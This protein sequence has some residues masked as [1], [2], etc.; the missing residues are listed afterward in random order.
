MINKNQ[1]EYT[2]IW[3]KNEIKIYDSNV[4]YLKSINIGIFI[5]I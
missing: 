1:T 3:L 5:I 2:S 4:E